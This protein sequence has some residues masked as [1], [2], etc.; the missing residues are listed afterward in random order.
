MRRISVH[1]PP[2]QHGPDGT[3][4][5]PWPSA[6]PHGVREFL[7]WMVTYDRRRDPTKRG[8][9]PVA[10]PAFAT[11]R[12]APD[13]VSL[14]WVG[15]S[16]FLIQIG[17]RNVLT[18]PMWGERASPVAFAGPRR[19][20]PPGV[21]FDEL[22]PVDFVVQ[23]HDHYDHL[24]RSTVRRLA[25]IHPSAEWV[26]PL[27]LAEWVA[28]HGVVRVRELDWWDSA[29]LD[30]TTTVT[31]TPAQHF[32]GRTWHRNRTLWAGWVLAA[33]GHR[34]YF[35]GDTGY[36]PEIGQAGARLGPFDAVLVPIGAYDP[37]WF[38]RPAHLDPEEAVRV[39]REVTG[40]QGDH[41]CT[42]TAMH[43]GTFK[44]T[45]EPLREPPE[46][47]R[48]AWHDA[49][50]PPDLLWIPTHGETRWLG[51]ADTF[52]PAHA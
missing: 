52:R 38:M 37:R 16:T 43:W 35:V 48:R 7:K 31:C 3:F 10:D 25:A 2:N 1:A 6:E 21:P 28:A 29:R 15:H 32:S 34:V 8:A 13:Q 12:A 51:D 47:A 36:F 17:D 4:R 39:Y 14:T 11:P 9:Q 30:E 46:R 42:M 22:P 18:D 23:S 5:N 26:V 27:G 45:E 49:G 20:M 41:A 50:L 44:L 24:D 40:H 19:F 33:G